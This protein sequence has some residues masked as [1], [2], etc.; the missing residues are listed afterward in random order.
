MNEN[1]EEKE[2]RV[3]KNQ[4]ATERQSLFEPAK[5][6]FDLAQ[7]G[8]SQERQ[9]SASSNTGPVKKSNQGA[10]TSSQSGEL[11]AQANSVNQSRRD[12]RGVVIQK[13]G[14]KHRIS[15]K[16]DLQTVIPVECWKQYNIES[17]VPQGTSCTCSIQ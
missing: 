16:N 12:S 7:D 10:S 3:K 1:G 11:N 9:R 5:K 17:N 13:G 2:K 6:S 14:K 8:K 15:F 4:V